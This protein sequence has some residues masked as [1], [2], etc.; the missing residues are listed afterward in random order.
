MLNVVGLKNNVATD[1]MVNAAN[2]KLLCYTDLAIDLV[3][4]EESAV[5]DFAVHLLA[6]LGCNQDGM[7][8]CAVIPLT[9][10]GQECHAKTHV[11]IIDS[12]DILLPVQENK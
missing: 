1:D 10:C 7:C 5:A 12:D 11:C 8:T 6:L 2:Y 3:P 9:I 4:A